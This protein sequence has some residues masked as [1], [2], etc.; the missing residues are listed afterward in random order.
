MLNITIIR[1]IQIRAT[2]STVHSSERQTFK[3]TDN[4]KWGQEF[5]AIGVLA[6]W[7]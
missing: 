6:Q 1:E 2:E 7:W 5:G 4:N 3:K